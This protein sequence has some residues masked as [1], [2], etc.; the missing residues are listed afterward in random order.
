[1]TN[2]DMDE[3]RRR[4]ENAEKERENKRRLEDATFENEARSTEYAD[5]YA[6]QMA[7]K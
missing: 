7:D 2:Y 4:S 6:Q 1:M 3:L 5:Q